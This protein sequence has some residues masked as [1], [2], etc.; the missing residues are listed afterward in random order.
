MANAGLEPGDIDVVEA[1]GTGTM[2]GDPIEARALIGVYGARREHGPLYVGSL[3]S[4]IGHTSAAAGVGG[5]I[6]MV[7]AL[8]LR[9]CR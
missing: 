6:K 4:N 9:C 7:Q 2:L 5:V 8:R 1:H 3:K